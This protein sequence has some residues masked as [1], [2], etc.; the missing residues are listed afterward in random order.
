M[1]VPWA[2]GTELGLP[3]APGKVPRC[4]GSSRSRSSAPGVT[5]L[6]RL[7]IG[8]RCLLGTVVPVDKQGKPQG[9]WAPRNFSPERWQNHTCEGKTVGMTRVSPARRGGLGV[10][11]VQSSAWK[12]GRPSVSALGPGGGASH[13]CPRPAQQCLLAA[14]AAESPGR[15]LGACFQPLLPSDDRLA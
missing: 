15:T 3:T 4:P 14:P 8:T 9:I 7:K 11:S 1:W 13:R 6:S 2:E 10:T 12:C 5:A